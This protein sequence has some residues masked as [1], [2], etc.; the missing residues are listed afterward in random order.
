MLSKLLSKLGC[1][2]KTHL[3]CT[4]FSIFC[5]CSIPQRITDGPNKRQKL[6]DSLAQEADDYAYTGTGG[7]YDFGAM[8]TGLLI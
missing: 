5:S 7:D 4:V 8:R 1:R 3:V 2:R 6:H